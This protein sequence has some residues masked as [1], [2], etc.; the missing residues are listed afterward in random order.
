[1][2][3]YSLSYSRGK[4]RKPQSLVAVGAFVCVGVTTSAAPTAGPATRPPKTADVT[5]VFPT[6][7]SPAKFRYTFSRSVPCAYQGV[8]AES[9]NRWSRLGLSFVRAKKSPAR[10]RGMKNPARWRGGRC[11]QPCRHPIVVRSRPDATAAAQIRD[12][13]SCRVHLSGHAPARQRP[14]RAAARV[15]TCR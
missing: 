7:E 6:C 12:F 10:G 8:D 4:Y 14:G 11:R 9:L 13:C 3:V 2:Q 5:V 1:M 15:L